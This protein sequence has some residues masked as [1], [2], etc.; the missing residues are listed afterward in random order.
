ML[1]RPAWHT[2]LMKEQSK[3]LETVQRRALQ[4]IVGYIPYEEAC[5]LFDLP[6]LA[7]RRS[8]LCSTLFKQITSESHVLQYLLPVK[9]DAQLASRLR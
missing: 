4:I 3:S 6:T 7:E 1:V 5:R 9:R 2:S 8:S